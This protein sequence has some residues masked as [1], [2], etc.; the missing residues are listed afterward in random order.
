MEREQEDNMRHQLDLEFDNIRSIVYAPSSGTGSNSVPLGPIRQPPPL[1]ANVEASVE[2]YDQHVRELAF[3]Q[4]AKPK[5]RTKTEEEIAMEE[6]EKLEQ[7]ELKR[8]KRMMGMDDSSDE[9]E[10]K[11]RKKRKREKGGDD[12]EDDFDHEHTEWNTLGAG[13]G[14]EQA[15]SSDNESD[16]SEED[17]EGT[18]EGVDESETEIC[19]RQRGLREEQA[20]GGD[21]ESDGSEEDT[22]GTDGDV[23]ESE[24]EI[25][26]RQ[27]LVAKQRLAKGKSKVVTGN[28]LPFTFPCPESHDQ[29]LDIIEDVS[30]KDVP[31]VV[32]RI[33]TLYHP[34]LGPE[35][36]FKL[37]VNFI[38]SV[39]EYYSFSSIQTLTT[40]IIDYTLYITSPPSPN[41]SLLSSIMPHLF[42]L[43][44]SYPEQSAQHFVSKLS[45]MQKNLKRGLSLGSLN[46]DAKTWP[47]LLELSFLQ[48]IGAIWPTSDMNHIVIS[49]TRLLMGAY[50]G[51][52]RV[53]SLADIASGLFLCTLFIDFEELSK[54]FVPEAVN[55]VVNALLHL[56]PHPFKS[57]ES[58]P[59]SFPA[60]DF[61]SELCK[62]LGVDFSK[63]R[64]T[65]SQ[66]PDLIDILSMGRK[67][68]QAKVDLLGLSF[69]LIGRFADIY[70][71]L[72]GYIELFRPISDVIQKIDSSRL[73]PE[74]QVSDP[75]ETVAYVD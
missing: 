35:N 43:T 30:E 8:R 56:A 13:L 72:D 74:Q 36:K 26:E 23:D 18:D 42:A 29:F 73:I 51:L 20:E 50:L 60:P 57:V 24:T 11:S 44:R 66:K 75:T 41:F 4:R 58:L 9:D 2:A 46:P 16:G 22:E 25:G 49:P 34:S 69:D 27:E 61:K 47:G 62:G 1:T 40:V 3:D 67:D 63:A 65:V 38:Y 70:K 45:L 31:K 32:Q 59:G 53:R 71:S 15:E 12:L 5:D 21:N 55:F 64:R 14:D 10:G 68:E 52:G 7:A 37:E 48:V 33:R 54:R 6:K 17:A 39:P 19:E 28:E